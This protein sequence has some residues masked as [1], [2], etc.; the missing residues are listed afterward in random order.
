MQIPKQVSSPADPKEPSFLNLPA[1]IRNR[2]YEFLFTRDEPVL[3]HN[4]KA[5]HAV[6]PKDSHDPNWRDLIA[7]FDDAYDNEIKQGQF[8]LHDLQT[9]TPA[10]VVCRQVYAEAVGHLYGNN[11]FM[12]SR[13]LYRHDCGNGGDDVEHNNESYFVTNYVAQWLQGLGSQLKLLNEVRIDVG[14]CCPVN[15]D[16]GM[17]HI[18]I[19]NLVRMLWRYPYLTDVVAFTQREPTDREKNNFGRTKHSENEHD[20]KYAKRLQEILIAIGVQDVL[21]LKR[22]AYTD[23]LVTD[24]DLDSSLYSGYVDG[25]NLELD[26]EILEEGGIRWLKRSE[27]PSS[28]LENL[29]M[30]LMRKIFSMVSFPAGQIVIDS[31]LHTVY[32]F[33]P[34]IFQLNRNLRNNILD[35]LPMDTSIVIRKRI[36]TTTSDLNSLIAAAAITSMPT[37]PSRSQFIHALLLRSLRTIP[38]HQLSISIVLD[39]D[40]VTA[41]SLE[42]IRINIKDVVTLL[43]GLSSSGKAEFRFVLKCPWG[44]ATHH[45]EFTI[46]MAELVQSLFLLL[47]DAKQQWSSEMTKLSDRQL[48]DI[49]L[50]R[51]GVLVSA[52]LPAS[53]HSSK[54]S[55]EYAHGRLTP[56]EIRNRGY[57]MAMTTGPSSDL[58]ILGE[59]WEYI[60]RYL[61]DDRD[62]KRV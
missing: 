20:M 47:S 21:H 55:V 42:E 44:N 7:A 17:Q 45:E 22:Y 31:D 54:R 52:S 51:N 8:F 36:S 29:K 56:T 15:C 39:F 34:V 35:Q 24:I 60:R 40:M 43:L 38:C 26:F 41:T 28:P 4:A 61:Y 33:H 11:T 13:P 27:T 18:S 46:P 19:L 9:V 48:P 23:L 25:P 30:P 49:W 10:L 5:Y 57:R 53:S 37:E 3:L 2:I 59:C 12:F 14:A 16:Q 32:G 6:P 58:G 1:E 62:W 50:N